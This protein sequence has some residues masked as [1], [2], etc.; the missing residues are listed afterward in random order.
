MLVGVLDVH[1]NLPN[2][3]CNPWLFVDAQ[4]IFENEDCFRPNILNSIRLAT[5]HNTF[6][7]PDVKVYDWM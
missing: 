1:V 2:V 3:V 5:Y 4:L 6:E 7:L